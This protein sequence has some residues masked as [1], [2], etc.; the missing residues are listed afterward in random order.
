MEDLAVL[1]K[2]VLENH[3]ETAEGCWGCHEDDAVV[4]RPEWPCVPY[5]IASDWLRLRSDLSRSWRNKSV[6]EIQLNSP[7]FCCMC[8][9]RETG[10]VCER[11][12]MQADEEIA[13]E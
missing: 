13:S 10:L 7:F 6:E 1:V 9:G 2:Q 5:R 12:I 8:S 3:K 11:C 4:S